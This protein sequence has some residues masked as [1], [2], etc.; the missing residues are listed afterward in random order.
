MGRARGTLFSLLLAASAQTQASAADIRGLAGFVRPAYLAMNIAAMCARGDPYFLSDTSGP[1][2]TALHYAQH[3]KDEAIEQLT[4]ADAVAVLKLAA[5]D[6]RNAARA[7][8]YELARPGDDVG[9]ALAIKEWCDS[10]AR[11]I[12]LR[13][14]S[15]HDDT[16][17][18]SEQFL[19]QA[20]R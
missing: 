2:G 4:Q 17:P 6:A 12:V 15:N 10:K 3:V 14:I 1:R 16:H 18:A 11:R 5:D 20:K 13:F 7:M 9:T 19:E 8:L